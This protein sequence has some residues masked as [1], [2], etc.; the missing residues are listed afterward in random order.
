M[1]EL[2]NGSK[3]ALEQLQQDHLRKGRTS[4]RTPSAEWRTMPGLMQRENAALSETRHGLEQARKSLSS[5]RAG[6][7]RMNGIEAHWEQEPQRSI[8]LEL[9][10]RSGNGRATV[11][12]CN[13]PDV[14][15]LSARDLR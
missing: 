1:T 10:D 2:K 15:G 9:N 3:S 5:S 12:R 14:M 11:R 7:R 13:K 8:R 4:G 6:C